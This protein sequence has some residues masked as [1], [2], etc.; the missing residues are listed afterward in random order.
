MF[1]ALGVWALA[2]PR[3][4]FDA[5]AVFEPYN[6]HFIH[7]IGAF[8]IGFG[9]VLILGAYLRDAL[10][11]SLSGVAVGAL[12]HVVSHVMDRGLGGQPASDI[13]LFTVV[14]AVLVAAAVVRAGAPSRHR[15]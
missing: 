14:A 2:G 13:P 8:Q 5:V 1:F 9:A 15:S 4:F 11:V 7:D 3:S 12:M 6:T 10:L